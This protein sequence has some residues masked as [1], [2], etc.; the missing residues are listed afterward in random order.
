MFSAAKQVYFCILVL[1]AIFL[2]FSGE[3]WGVP[4]VAI[5]GGD[6]EITISS[7]T[8]GQE[9]NSVIDE[10]C[11]LEWVTLGGGNN[12]KKI[13]VQ[14]NL[15]PQKFTLAVEARNVSNGDGTAVGK[16]VLGNGSRDLITGIPS[17][18][19]AG[20]PGTCT[21]RYTASAATSDGTGSDIHTI[22]YTILDE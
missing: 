15:F 8:A 2:V 4:D 21:L 14:S 5:V 7:A 3:S 1:A 9:P 12:N 16:V 6:V 20:D 18:L 17:T 10:T 19:P 13:T 22:T 11:Q